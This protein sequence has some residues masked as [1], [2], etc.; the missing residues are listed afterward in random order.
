MNRPK[1][2][3]TSVNAGSVFATNTIDILA[4]Y[5]A[6]SVYTEIVNYGITGISVRVNRDNDCIIDRGRDRLPLS[7]RCLRNRLP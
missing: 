2:I 1:Y 3:R 5:G 6:P 7:A 4:T